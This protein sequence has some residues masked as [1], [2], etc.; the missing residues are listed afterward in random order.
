MSARR[1][2]G[3]VA[4]AALALAAGIAAPAAA[5]SGP[6]DIVVTVPGPTTAP[7][8]DASITNAELRWGLNAES[9]AGAF[10]GGCNFLSA[11]LAGDAGG[12]RVWRESDALYRSR[13][14]SVRVEKPTSTGEWVESTWATKCLDPRGVAVSASS[15]ASTSG[16]QVVMQGGTGSLVDGGVSIRWSGSFTV[17]YYGG[18]TYWSVTDP[19]LTLDASGSGRLTGLASGFGTSMDDMTK[20]QALPPR[21][22]TLADIRGAD[23]A[24]GAGFSVTPQ[25]LG[26]STVG[27]GQVARSAAN[28][29]HWGSFPQSFVDFHGLTGQQGYWLTTGGIRD[30]AKPASPLTVSYDAAAPVAPPVGGTATTATGAT[31]VNPVRRAPAAIP[32]A[33]SALQLVAA[34]T[35]LTLQPA[36]LDLIPRAPV[37]SSPVLLP[38]LI[39]ATALSAAIVAVL[40]MMGALPWSRPRGVRV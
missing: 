13:D 6:G 39:A 28:E 19:V 18:M 37:A 23:V 16:N 40:S 8:P 35:P 5:A 9:G 32:A 29:T 33:S 11:G 22:V 24:A 31:P 38:L 21:T 3:A 10:A 4:L 26:V 12:A 15:T 1:L 36:P 17:A 14:G 34:N 2:R 20:W 25:Y 27:G 30:A 7:A